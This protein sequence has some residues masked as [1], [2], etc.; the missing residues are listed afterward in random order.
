MSTPF[1]CYNLIMRLT[2]EKRKTKLY[3]PY[4]FLTFIVIGILSFLFINFPPNYSFE[5]IN[6]SIPVIYLSFALTFLSIY[7]LG[8][9]I[10]RGSVHGIILSA[11][12]I[13]YLVLRV[14]G[15]RQTF[16][17]FLIIAL[18]ISIELLLRK[19]K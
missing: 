1:C 6:L 12:V 19:K 7:F 3:L 8:T 10:F 18:F 2:K 16:F 17:L 5:V 9:F 4:L 13:S 11:L 14:V 15:I